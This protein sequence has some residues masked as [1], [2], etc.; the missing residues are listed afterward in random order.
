MRSTIGTS[1]SAADGVP[2]ARQEAGVALVVRAVRLAAGPGCWPLIDRAFRDAYGRRDGVA[3]ACLFRILLQGLA[4]GARRKLRL[5]FPGVPELT[6]DERALVQLIAAAQGGD[7][8]L[9]EAAL[10]WLA[11]PGF[12]GPVARTA[13]ELGRL[14]AANGTVLPRRTGEPGV[15]SR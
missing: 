12:A 14:M 4:L 3:A 9:L 8:M 13:R 7:R 15:P 1:R 10:L 5:G 6:P 11:R 2:A